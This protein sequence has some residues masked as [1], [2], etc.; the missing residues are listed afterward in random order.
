VIP[1]VMVTVAATVTVNTP[2]AVMTGAALE[3]DFNELTVTAWSIVT[4]L[5]FAYTSS[6]DAG[7]VPPSHVEVA[8]QLPFAT[9]YLIAM[10]MILT[11]R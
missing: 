2:P 5:L 10:G 1:A 6:V 3:I 8:D 9:A 11:S 4:N 7:N